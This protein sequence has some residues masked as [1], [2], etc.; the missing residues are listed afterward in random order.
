MARQ[1]TLGRR[2]CGT[3]TIAGAGWPR[4]MPRHCPRAANPNTA[5]LRRTPLSPLLPTAAGQPL[6]DRRRDG[7]RR[8]RLAGAPGRRAGL[9]CSRAPQCRA[10]SRGRA[11]PPC[12]PRPIAASS[13][14]NLDR[15]NPP[16]SRPA[17]RSCGCSAPR[18]WPCPAG[19]R[20][21]PRWCTRRRPRW[22]PTRTRCC[23]AT[24]R[25]ARRCAAAPPRRARRRRRRRRRPARLAPRLGR[26]HR[27]GARRRAAGARGAGAGRRRRPPAAARGARAAPRAAP[28]GAAG[29][30][31]GRRR[32]RAR[33]PGGGRAAGGG[34]ARDAPPGPRPP[35]LCLK[36]HETLP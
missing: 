27:P 33:Q 15:A 1:N 19:A 18:C 9:D 16:P 34:A 10:R 7:G 35:R 17:A 21:C 36:S 11:P 24:G 29:G 5:L 14:P 23:P 31:E 13:A 8:A 22:R 32:E 3:H 12:A 20:P 4:C 2:R 26:R 25:P 30:R 28:A 6:D